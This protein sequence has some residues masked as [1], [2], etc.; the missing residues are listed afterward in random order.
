MITIRHGLFETNSSSTHTLILMKTSDFHKWYN[1]SGEEPDD[2]ALFVIK[3][4]DGKSSS[5]KLITEREVRE[6]LENS[7]SWMKKHYQEKPTEEEVLEIAET[8][9]EKVQ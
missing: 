8:I 9:R 1:S 6:A 2:D 5:V 4:K 3:L 7:D